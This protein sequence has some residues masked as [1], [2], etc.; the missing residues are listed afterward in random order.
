M[1]PT[2][3][4][5][6]SWGGAAVAVFSLAMVALAIGLASSGQ[7]PPGWMAGVT[8]YGLPVAF[9][10]LGAALVAGFIDRRKR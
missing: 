6:A 2:F 1:A 8:L 9:A 5:A 3:R 7:T 10:L 4:R